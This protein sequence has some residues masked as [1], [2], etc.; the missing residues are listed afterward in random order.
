MAEPAAKLRFDGSSLMRSSLMWS[1]VITGAVITDVVI[2]AASG[3][4]ER[5]PVAVRDLDP[6]SPRLATRPSKGWIG[7]GRTSSILDTALRDERR[8]GHK[9]HKHAWQHGHLT[10]NIV[11][12]NTRSGG[13]G[14]SHLSLIGHRNLSLMGSS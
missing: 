2:S 4:S 14:C 3:T 6:G 12:W 13:P 9:A 10:Q 1:S 7:G 5:R 8:V 11:S